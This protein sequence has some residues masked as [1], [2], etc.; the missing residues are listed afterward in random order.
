[1]SRASLVGPVIC[2]SIGLIFLLNAF[3]V[4]KWNSRDPNAQYLE[5]TKTNGA[6][7]HQRVVS[8]AE[9]NLESV[10]YASVAAAFFLLFGVSGFYSYWTLQPGFVRLGPAVAGAFV[11]YWVYRL[12]EVL[13]HFVDLDFAVTAMLITLVCMIAL[14]RLWR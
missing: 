10:E 1:M 9:L 7:T 6:I 5:T 2:L 11:G 8:G 4:I 13:P 3:D 14:N 12:T